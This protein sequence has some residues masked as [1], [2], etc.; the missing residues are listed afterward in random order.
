[1]AGRAIV[2]EV[3]LGE[4]RLF[5]TLGQFPFQLAAPAF[6]AGPLDV[7]LQL[8]KLTFVLIH[9][10]LCSQRFTQARGRTARGPVRVRKPP[11]SHLMPSR[12]GPRAGCP[13]RR[14][15]RAAFPTGPAPPGAGPNPVR[16]VPPAP[17][18]AC[19]GSSHR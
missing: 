4:R 8:T 18:L 19:G 1:E 6:V 7:A 14:R 13:G 2:P 16:S 17:A 12:A 9:T 3:E 10:S 15:H 5:G 11:K